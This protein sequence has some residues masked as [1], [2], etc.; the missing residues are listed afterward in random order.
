MTDKEIKKFSK[1][2]IKNKLSKSVLILVF[3][4]FSLIFFAAIPYL[5]ITL[6]DYTGLKDLTD[7]YSIYIYPGL[8]AI[9]L[10]GITIWALCVYSSVSLG[11][12]AWFSG[13]ADRRTNC[14]K[15]LCFWFKPSRSFKALKFN[16]LLIIIKL[17]WGAVFLSPAALMFTAVAILASSGGIEMYLF[18]SL[19]CGGTVL[20]ITGLIFWF[21]V[22][23]RYFL[24][25]YLISSNPR[26]GAY[27]AIKQSRNLLDGYILRIVRFKLS[28]IPWF[29][30][31]PFIFP[32]IY[33][34][35]YYKQSCSVIAK[36]ICL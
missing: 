3:T 22:C 18:I 12:K 20:A 19:A 25:P 6:A 9:L 36:E 17:M 4:I 28:F 30:L 33:T 31:N 34:Y 1:N 10:I 14:G 23:Q 11:E 16:L 7:A 35:P 29:Q 26:L 27:Q 13:T 2:L 15:R 5:L 8:T 24:A 21:I 32:I